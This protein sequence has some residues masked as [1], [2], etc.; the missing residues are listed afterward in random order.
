MAL[1][2]VLAFDEDQ[3]TLNILE[4]QLIQRYAHDYRVECLV[5][6]NL[7]LSR[8][9]ELADVGEEVALVLAAKSESVAEAGGLLEHVRELHPHA[10]CASWCRGT[11]GQTRRAQ[12][13]SEPHRVR[14]RSLYAVRPAGP[15][16]E[17]FHEAVSSFLLEWATERRIVPHTIQIVGESWSGRAYELRETFEQCAAPHTFCLADSDEGRELLT[18]AGPDASSRS[19]FFPMAGS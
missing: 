15:P 8:L 14:A 3:D 7:A 16:D 5:D 17:V 12:M 2:V 13:R 9:T 4:N 6:P 18:K 1:P 11:S 19:W 10:K